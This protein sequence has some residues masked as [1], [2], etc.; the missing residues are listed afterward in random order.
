M[1][2]DHLASV[3]GTEGY[4]EEAENLFRRYENIS[5]AD[6]HASVLHL[7]PTAPCRA[8]DIGS[9]TGRDAAALAAMGHTVVAVEPTSELRLRAARFHP[10]LRIEWQDDSL[11]D[12]T[13]VAQ[14]GEQFDL[15]MLTAV[16]MHLDERQRRRAM[17]RI[18]SLVRANG[19]VIMT[20][21]HG[22]VPRGR[23]MFAIAADE[24]I[25]LAG[26]EGLRLLVNQNEPSAL[27]TANVS[28]SRLA[29]AKIDGY[30]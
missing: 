3:S 26:S 20:L 11:P 24:T 10:S 18:A 16:W 17:R 23:R 13:R 8:L 21:R 29:F 28:W 25:G 14:R 5:F 30:A 6:V 2:C 1:G 22:P 19:I 27:G 7:I 12:L 4:A 9:G 15:V